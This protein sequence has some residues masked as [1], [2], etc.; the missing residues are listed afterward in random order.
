MRFIPR[1]VASKTSKLSSFNKDHS[2]PL[3]PFSTSNFSMKRLHHAAKASGTQPSSTASPPVRKEC[4]DRLTDRLI[5]SQMGWQRGFAHSD[6]GLAAT[7][8]V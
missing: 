4:H 2:P 8:V 7:L 6:P 3:R 1:S 5:N